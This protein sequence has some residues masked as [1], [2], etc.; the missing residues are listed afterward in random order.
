[1]VLNM[2]ARH[3]CQKWKLRAFNTI[4]ARQNKKNM[5][6]AVGQMRMRHCYNMLKREWM[7][8]GTILT[9]L[10]NAGL[11]VDRI[12]KKHALMQILQQSNLTYVKHA[13]DRDNT[14]MIIRNCF[15]RFDRRRVHKYFNRMK[16]EKSNVL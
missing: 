10:A 9:K 8:K 15:E 3:A 7:L 5:I 14:Y 11:A 16:I 4:V 13:R 6:N 2:R 12:H 1:M